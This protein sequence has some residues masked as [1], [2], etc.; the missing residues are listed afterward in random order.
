MMGCC[1]SR[2]RAVQQQEGLPGES[3]LPPAAHQHVRLL[4]QGAFP[5]PKAGHSR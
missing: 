1:G 5:E 3:D 2:S 4:V